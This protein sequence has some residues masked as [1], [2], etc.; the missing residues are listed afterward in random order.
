[1]LR[2]FLRNVQAK[3]GNFEKVKENNFNK[4]IW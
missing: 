2:K 1:M 4:V 3:F